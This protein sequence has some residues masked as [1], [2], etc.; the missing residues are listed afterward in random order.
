MKIDFEGRTWE[1][2]SDRIGIDEWREIKRKLKMTPRAIQEGINEAD[3][4]S[5]TVVYW[6]MLRQDGQ[7]NAV[8]SDALKPDIIALNNAVGTAN[9]REE[10][11][12]AA[13]EQA[14]LEA[15]AAKAAELGPTQPAGPTS[16]GPLSL[17]DTTLTPLG[18]PPAEAPM[19]VS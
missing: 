13:R 14:D 17:T 6:T 7:Q 8:L 19:T 3:P 5:M 11:E 1:W 10:A 12:Q 2:D 16:P 18:Q 4:D 9:E 15:A